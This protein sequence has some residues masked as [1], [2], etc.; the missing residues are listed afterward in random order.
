MPSI[1]EEYNPDGVD[2]AWNIAQN[3]EKDIE[4]GMSTQP[5]F[6]EDSQRWDKNRKN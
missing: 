4:P 1:S 2:Q 6:Q 3:G 5:D